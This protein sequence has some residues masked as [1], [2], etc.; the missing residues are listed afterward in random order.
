MKI[1]TLVSMTQ[2]EWRGLPIAL[3]DELIRVL[4]RDG[5]TITKSDGEPA[6]RLRDYL[7]GTL[8]LAMPRDGR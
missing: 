7:V 6:E 3:A 2:D 4:E 8:S 1:Q 5:Y